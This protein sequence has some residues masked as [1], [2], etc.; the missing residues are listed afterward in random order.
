[1]DFLHGLPM[2]L[3]RTNFETAMIELYAHILQFLAR[4]IQT[5]QTSTFQQAFRAFWE[6][7]DIEEFEKHATSS[8]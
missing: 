5:Y 3:T 6:D 7:S 8:E 1:M 2:T 4:A